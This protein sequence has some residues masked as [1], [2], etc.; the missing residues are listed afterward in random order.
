MSSHII[1]GHPGGSHTND[2]PDATATLAEI[3]KSNNFTSK[4]PPDPQYPTPEDSHKAPRQKLGPRMVRGALYTY[5]RPEPTEEPEILAVSQAALRDIGLAI[6]EANSEEFKQVVAGNKFYWDEGK[7]GVYPWAQCYG[8]FQFGSWAGQLGDGRAISL[9]ETTNPTTGVRYELQLKGAGKTPYSRFADGKA[10]LRSSIR[11]FVVSEYLNAIGI[12]TTRALSLTLCPKSEV[13][14]ERLEPGAIVCRF[15]QTWL[16]FGTFDLLRSRG[17]R[18]LIRKLATYIAEDVF[19]GWDKLPAALP[20]DTKDAHL[21][22][23][24]GA[25]KDELQGKE[26]AEENRFARLYREIARRSALLVGKMQAYGFMNG[27]LNT[28]NT[29]IFGL[30]LDYGPFAFMDNFDPA[31]TPNHDD[32]MLRY[33]YRAQPSIFWWNLVRL[34]ETLGELIGAGDKADDEVFVEKGIEEDFAPVLIKR[35]ETI[36]DQVADEYKAVFMSEYRRLMTRRLGLRTQKES[37]FE[38]LFS[39]LLDMMEALELDFNH[40]FRRL[41]SVK[42]SDISTKD[43]R[44][45]TAE[46][47]FHQGGVTGL[48][49]TSDTAREKIGAWLDQWRARIVEDWDITSDEASATADEQREKEMKSIN[50]N[51]VPRGWLLDDIIDRV[52]N[53]HE[54]EILKGVMEMTLRPFDDEWQWDE[55]IE[56]KYCGDVPRFQRAIQC[57][58]SS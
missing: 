21:D 3:P 54:R 36:I 49:E 45:K 58:C 51:F 30:S 2:Y 31:Y 47:F 37:D 29:S 6:S 35:A 4:L 22:P 32:H 39:E 23:A 12:P 43:T 8:G 52:Q 38:K 46:R 14:R 10:V 48:N 26:G 24:R 27:V 1:D 44:E 20:A 50:P 15:A 16:R 53:K 41:S 34:G 28:D 57:S 55:E 9:F 17:D 5:V 40:F 7:G 56:K 19:G 13:I 25:P 11:E 33:S 18:D 42:L